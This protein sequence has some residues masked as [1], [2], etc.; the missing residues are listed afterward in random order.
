MYNMTQK[1]FIKRKTRIAM[2]V[3]VILQYT[4]VA[5]VWC[6]IV[7]YSILQNTTVLLQYTTTVYYYSILLLQE[8]TTVYYSI[9][10]YKYCDQILI[11]GGALHT[12]HVT[13][14]TIDT[15]LRSTVYTVQRTQQLYCVRCTVISKSKNEHTTNI[16]TNSITKM[17]YK[18]RLISFTR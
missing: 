9:L 7:Y 11:S 16:K 4:I 12:A 15:L 1:I 5:R 18:A 6:Q 10:Q 8:T 13:L 3:V 2:P 14:H 17:D